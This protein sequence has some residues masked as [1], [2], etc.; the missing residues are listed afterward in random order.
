MDLEGINNH[1]IIID[2]DGEKTVR[3]INI[4]RSHKPRDN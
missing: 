2:I 4:Y 1:L 3:L